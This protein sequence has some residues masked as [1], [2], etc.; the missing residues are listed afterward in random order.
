[1]RVLTVADII[2][3][4]FRL[5]RARIGSVAIW[6]LLYLAINVAVVYVTRPYMAD[7]M[8]LQAAQRV[9][10]VAPAAMLGSMA[11]MFGVYLL[12]LLGLL[13]LYTAALRAA[14]RPAE[15]SFAYLRLGMDELRILLVA[16]ALTIAFFI[17]YVLLVLIVSLIGAAIGFM[18]RDALI[19]VAI[20]L[21][22]AVFCVLLF[23]QVRFSLAFALTLLRGKIMIG[24]S[25]TLTRGRFWTL[26]GA[27]FVLALI[28]FASAMLVFAITAGPYWAELARAGTSPAAVNAAAQHQMERQFS[29]VTPLTV[30]GWLLGAGFGAFWI[31]LLAGAAG[32]ATTG[33]L[34]EGFAD[35]GAIYE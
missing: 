16:V 23:F 12:M 26:F 13:V 11:Q 32:A 3:G 29:A 21:M 18:A 35:V 24:E 7:M 31:A 4:G 2:G 14:V 6:A 28:V 5:V 22:V 30:V 25:W 17:L 1:M 9:G 33:L 27:Y 10:A 8:A 20:V 15:A 34:D 19:P